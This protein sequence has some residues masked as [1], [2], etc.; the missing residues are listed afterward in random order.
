MKRGFQKGFLGHIVA[1]LLVTFVSL[2]LMEILCQPS[3]FPTPDVYVIIDK[4]MSFR[5]I[6]ERLQSQGLVRNKYVFMLL[7]RILGIE[8]KAKAGRYRFKSTTDMLE[9]LARL[10]RGETYRQIVL[11]P[12]GRTIESVARIL[13]RCTGIDSLAFVTAA[14]DSLFVKSL[15]IPARTAEG[16]LFPGSYE[17]EWN[18]EPQSLIR[19]MVGS[20]FEV[21]N[22]SMIARAKELG[23]DL[24]EIVALASIIEKEAMLDVERPR[25]SA[26]FHNRLRLRMKLQA[27]PTVRYAL[28]K[29]TG[30]LRYSDLEVDSPFNTYR[31]YGLPPSPICSPGLA[32]LLAALYPA[33]G[34]KDLFFVARGD[35][36]HYFSRT[37]DEHNYFTK[38]YHRYLDSL[39]VLNKAQSA[40]SLCEKSVQDVSL[41][42][43]T[44]LET[45]GK[46]RNE[47]GN[48]E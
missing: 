32:S 41:G 5:Q 31:V 35:G 8:K 16:Y 3:Y 7:S 11:I 9:I 29:W 4:G 18:E 33:E 1:I 6:A 37:I 14:N 42:A 30:R 46:M 17:V 22:D 21:M 40:D 26:V 23:M 10:Y 12:P 38:L 13:A 19:R 2:I 45:K 34:S 27:D 36:S 43:E 47:V 20:F 39:E 28:R 15:G 24:N 48:K 44:T 25:I